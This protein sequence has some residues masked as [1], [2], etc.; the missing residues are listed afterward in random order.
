MKGLLEGVRVLDITQMLA[1][2]YGSM[3]LADMGAEVIK[4]ESREG[5]HTRLGTNIA[6]KGVS[7][8]FLAINRNKKS[9]A[10]DLKSSEGRSVFYDLVKV[11]DVVLDNM[12]PKAL[13]KLQCGYDD[14][15]LIN[16]RIISCSISGFGHT[17]PY[18]DLPAFDMTI[19][20]ISG[21]LS[22]TGEEDGEPAK[23]GLPIADEAAGLFAAFGIVSALHY[24]DRTGKGQE[25]DISMMDC[26]LSLASYLASFY[27]IGG[28][29]PKAYGTRHPSVVPWGAFKTKDIWIAI[30]SVTSKQ[31]EGLCRVLER[32]D[33]ITD[34]RFSTHPDRLKNYKELYAILRQEFLRKD[35]KEWL[36]LLEQ[37]NSPA[38]P[39]N[40]LDKALENPHTTKRQ[41]VVEIE[42]PRIG[43]F[44]SVGNPIKTSESETTYRCAPDL[45]EHT[46]DVL[47]N[48]LGYPDK[49]ITSLQDDRIIALWDGADQGVERD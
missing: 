12:R 37:E 9:V 19:Q 3:L 44:K 29:V 24:R 49:K 27:F 10:I 31:W 17:G 5:D 43:T 46:E 41:M 33:L 48:I 38:A 14:L 25:L 11:S 47:K 6:Q 26:Q 35:G 16:P 15:K 1:G 20:A 40:T 28:V 39:V 34:D 8:Y 2:P 32:E 36:C 22:M 7:A 4:I 30:T 18:Q 42:H 21:G 13:R 23:M 45:G